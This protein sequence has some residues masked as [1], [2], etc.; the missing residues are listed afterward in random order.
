MFTK[1]TLQRNADATEVIAATSVAPEN[2]NLFDENNWSGKPAEDAANAE[3]VVVAEVTPAAVEKTDV[4][5]NSFVKEHFGFDSLEVAKQEF[6][7]LKKPKEVESF[8]FLNDQSEKIFKALKEGKEDDIYN[9]LAQKKQVERLLSSEVDD[10]LAD[11]LLKVSYK[12]KN[13]ELTEDEVEFL[14]NKRFALPKKPTQALD[15]TDDEYEERV[16]NWQSDVNSI[17]KEKIIEAKLA[18]KEIEHLKTTIELP[19]FGV[20]PQTQP[21]QED[22]DKL[23]KMAALYEKDVETKCKSFEGVKVTAKIG[24]IELPVSFTPTDEDKVSMQKELLEFDVN[25]YFDGKWLNQDGTV[26]VD[27]MSS[28]YYFLKNKKDIIQKVANESAAKM[29][30]YIKKTYG[31]VSFKD[32]AKQTVFQQDTDSEQLQ[33]TKAFLNGM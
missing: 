24:D 11:E 33:A 6:E 8:K 32:D 31:N 19:N 14:L 7:N 13:K 28:D 3:P 18:K 12:A 15:E 16:G 2:V 21:K 23:E 30:E 29:F 1:T 17:N 20:A 4:D 27:E 5:Y 26:N 9:F 25:K 22:L 10:K